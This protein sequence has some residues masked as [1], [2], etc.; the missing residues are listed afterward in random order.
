M[1]AVWHVEV[2]LDAREQPGTLVEFGTQSLVIWPVGL[3]MGLEIWWLS[4]LRQLI[5]LPLPHS[6]C[7]APQ[8]KHH[9]SIPKIIVPKAYLIVFHL[10]SCGTTWNLVMVGVEQMILHGTLKSQPF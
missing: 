6:H 1:G 10:K 4:E 9:H 7:R 3:P 8:A 2:T 5:P